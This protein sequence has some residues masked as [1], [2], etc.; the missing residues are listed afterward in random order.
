MLIFQ[1]KNQTLIDFIKSILHGNITSVKKV[2]GNIYFEEYSPIVQA[3]FIIL[4]SN[5]HLTLHM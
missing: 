4:Q 5:Y 1:K 3:K 2:Q